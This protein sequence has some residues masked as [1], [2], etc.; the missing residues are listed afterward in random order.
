LVAADTE[1]MRLDKVDPVEA[2]RKDR[3]LPKRESP[4]FLSDHK[5]ETPAPK[6]DSF[7]DDLGYYI[8]VA[9]ACRVDRGAL[10][11]LLRIDIGIPLA[12]ILKQ[13]L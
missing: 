9:K 2:M 13:Y 6:L 10:E 3:R 8:E 1:G 7:E 5:P 4:S 12:K 11:I